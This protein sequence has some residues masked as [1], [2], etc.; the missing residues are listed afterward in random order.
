MRLVFVSADIRKYIIE[1]FCSKLIDWSRKYKF[2]LFIFDNLEEE[3]LILKIS[4]T[5]IFYRCVVDPDRIR[6][7]PPSFIDSNVF[8]KEDF[9]V[10]LRELIK[11][12]GGNYGI[13]K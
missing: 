3:D 4:K 9:V 8:S 12:D 5:S 1:F 2:S 11:T 6:Y 10:M 7:E 13:K